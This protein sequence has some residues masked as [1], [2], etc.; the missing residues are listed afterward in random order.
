MAYM[1]NIGAMTGGAFASADFDN[2]E[3]SMPTG[4]ML[5]VG[6][7]GQSDPYSIAV[8]SILDKQFNE[9]REK[10]S[11]TLYSSSQWKRRFR[12]FMG[13]KN[14]DLL[15]F[16][17]V[18]VPH[19]PVLGPGEI[20][21]RRFGNPQVTPTHPSVRDFVLDGSG[22]PAVDDINAALIALSGQEPLKDYI[23]QTQ[24]IFEMYREAGEEALK[25]QAMLKTKLDKLD[26]IQGKISGLFEIEPNETYEPLMQANEAYLKK[27]YDDT[28]IEEDYTAL[29][30]AYRRFVAIRE[31]AT[32]A[33]TVLAQESEPLCSI[34]LDESVAFAL[35][36]CGHTFCQTC[37][38]KQNGTC[39]M[40]RTHIRDKLKLYFG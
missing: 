28:K 5:D 19:H 22:C 37:I 17:K 16:L 35:N 18:T 1:P 36:P 13:K 20:L 2:A 10:S 24:A 39:F 21:L 14:N 11:A 3:D 32:T 23:V 33:R 25:A 31:V 27:V 34:C 9:I 7:N 30:K 12:D 8:N 15:D 29:V 6:G 38:R 26:R 4:A 40:C